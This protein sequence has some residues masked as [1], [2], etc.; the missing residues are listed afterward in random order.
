M[1]VD[2]T[3][4]TVS[5][6]L[7]H[8]RELL[9]TRCWQKGFGHR[10]FCSSFNSLKRYFPVLLDVY[11]D[12][13]G[14]SEGEDIHA[15]YISNRFGFFFVFQFADHDGMRRRWRKPSIPVRDW[16][17]GSIKFGEQFIRR[18][19]KQFVAGRLDSQCRQHDDFA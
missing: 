4:V 10:V 3:A 7:R 19:L 16:F 5:R 15:N 1:F 2:V 17:Y 11:P 9:R 14:V 18:W 13:A 8:I 12:M 6:T